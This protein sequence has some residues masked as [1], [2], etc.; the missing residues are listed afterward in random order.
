M[1]ISLELAK[2]HLTVD[3]D[4]DDELISTYI[5][6]SEFFI[7]S[8]CMT[9]RTLSTIS[10]TTGKIHPLTKQA[11]LLKIHDLYEW[12]GEK[13]SANVFINNSITNLMYNYNYN[14]SY[15]K[16]INDLQ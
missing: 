12:R 15:E 1:Y 13:T 7:D 11:I 4:D 16:I 6:D 5:E 14:I 10:G 9:G 3:F 8:M 2:K